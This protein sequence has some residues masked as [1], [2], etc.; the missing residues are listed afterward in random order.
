MIA[1]RESWKPTHIF[2][3]CYE[4]SDTGRVRSIA[5]KRR[6]VNGVLHRYRSR[7]LN[8]NMRA[9]GYL[10]AKLSRDQ[11]YKT[12]AVHRLVCWAFCGP[13]P[14]RAHEVGHL[15]GTRDNN[16]APNLQWLT[17]QQNN[18]QKE[19]HGTL[20]AGSRNHNAKLTE[21]TVSMARSLYG[22]QK[23]ALSELGEMF[24]CDKG[25][26]HKAVSGRSWQRVPMPFTCD[27]LAAT[28]KVEMASY[29]E[30]VTKG[31]T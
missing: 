9:N 31:A 20:R 1:S 25:T 5:R 14:S 30:I 17:S 8:P 11:T 16:S 26:M 23:Y 28:H 18:R 6:D 2:S 10:Y 4:V 15:D 12:V 3:D 21:A 29:S 7:M 24:G 22:T 19:E 27:L 13:P